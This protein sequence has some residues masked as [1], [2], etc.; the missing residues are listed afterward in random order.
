[1]PANIDGQPLRHI[2]H[3]SPLW[4]RL[5]YAHRMP[6]PTELDALVQ[7]WRRWQEAERAH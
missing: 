4:Q 2:H 3:R 7:D 1:M 6:P 5:A